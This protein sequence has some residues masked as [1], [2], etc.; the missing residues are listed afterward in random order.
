MYHASSDGSEGCFRGR[1]L[2][3][4]FLLRYMAVE[5]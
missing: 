4:A 5:L 1:T 3:R 2:W